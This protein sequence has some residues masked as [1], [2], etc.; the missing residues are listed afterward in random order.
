MNASNSNPAMGVQYNVGA[1]TRRSRICIVFAFALCSG[2]AFLKQWQRL[3]LSASRHSVVFALCWER[4][5]CSRHDMEGNVHL[6]TN[7]AT[8]CS[9]LQQTATDCNTLQHIVMWRRMSTRW[10]QGRKQLLRMFGTFFLYTNWCQF[11]SVYW[12]II[13]C[14]EAWLNTL[15]SRNLLW[16]WSMYLIFFR[17]FVCL[18][19]CWPFASD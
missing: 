15:F 7:V 16:V 6:M 12:I 4:P 9:S 2:G 11:H 8:H 1:C 17:C 18:C 3:S 19:I 13:T 10:Q 5:P 14:P